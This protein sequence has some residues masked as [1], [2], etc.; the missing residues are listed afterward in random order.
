VHRE[1]NHFCV[2]SRRGAIYYLVRTLT[3]IAVLVIE[4]T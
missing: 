4:N 1:E 3:R 2:A